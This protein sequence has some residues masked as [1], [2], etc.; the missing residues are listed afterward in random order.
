MTDKNIPMERFH[1]MI[2]ICILEINSPSWCT[3]CT[4]CH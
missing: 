4:V 1:H 2:I 3:T